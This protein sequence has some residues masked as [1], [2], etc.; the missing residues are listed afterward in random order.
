LRLPS[1][2]EALIKYANYPKQNIL[3]L[4]FGIEKWLEN[5]NLSKLANPINPQQHYLIILQ[6]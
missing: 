1:L 4:K 2:F 5:R 6:N 3:I